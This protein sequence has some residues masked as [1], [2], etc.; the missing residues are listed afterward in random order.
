MTTVYK[1]AYDFPLFGLLDM[2]TNKFYDPS[3]PSQPLKTLTAVG[4]NYS[5]ILLRTLSNR[6]R[7]S[8]PPSGLAITK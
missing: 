7:R 4:K 8:K 2:C 5:F 3:Q 1:I 6:Q